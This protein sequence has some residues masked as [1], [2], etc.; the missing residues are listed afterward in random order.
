M[1]CPRKCTCWES[2]GLYWEGMPRQRPG[3]WGN[4]GGL[5]CLVTHNLGFYVDGID[6]QVVL[7]W[8]FWLRILPGGARVAQ[9][10]WMSIRRLLGCGRTHGVSIWLFPDC[11]KS[12]FSQI[13]DGILL[14]PYQ[15][16]LWLSN[17]CE[18]VLRFLA[19]VGSFSQCVSPNRSN[20]NAMYVNQ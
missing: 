14:V 1:N 17:S 19:M 13:V 11:G 3:W 6:F 18:Y 9:P 16:F 12:A 20:E 8:S 4:P 2:K 15:D 10:R 7:G 5:L